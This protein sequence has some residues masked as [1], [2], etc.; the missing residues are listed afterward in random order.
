MSFLFII[1]TFISLFRYQQSKEKKQLIFSLLF[2]FFA[3]LAKEYAITLL[4]LIPI[5]LYTKTLLSL[6]ESF[7]KTIP[8]FIVAIVY[9]FIRFSVVGKGGAFDNPDVLNN[10]FKFATASE[11][12]ATKIELLNHYLKLLFYPQPLSSDYSYNTIPYISFASKWVWAS[13]FIH[14]SMILTATDMTSIPH[15]F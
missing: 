10:P 8:F 13:I 4:L 3:L 7:V 6:K 9:L 15:N 14:L 1:L 5:L 11:K 12:W 2:Y